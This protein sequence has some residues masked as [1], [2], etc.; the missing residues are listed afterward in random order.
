[1]DAEFGQDWTIRNTTQ[2][3]NHGIGVNAGSGSRIQENGH[4]GFYGSGSDFLIAGNEIARNGYAGVDFHWEGGG[5]IV[6]ANC[7]HD[8]VGAGIWADIDVHRLVI[9]D[10]V[11]FG[12]RIVIRNVNA[13][14]GAVTDVDADNA[15]VA[16]GNRLYGNSYHLADRGGVWFWNDAEADWNAIRVQGQE[17]G[18]VL[19]AD[20]PQK[21]LLTCPSTAGAGKSR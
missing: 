16:T 17:A 1:M 18:S 20:M 3:L 2:R 9:E 19:H 15:V 7:V 14:I 8:N 10:N 21:A 11:V 4:A 5:G 13:R 6:R 12:N